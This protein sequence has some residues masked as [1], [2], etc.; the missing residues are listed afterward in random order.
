MNGL[1]VKL[2]VS[3]GAIEVRSGGSMRA[4]GT[5]SSTLMC[6]RFSDV[7]NGLGDV[8]RGV[9]A[10]LAQH[11]RRRRSQ[12]G[13]R[14][15]L[16][17]EQDGDRNRHDHGQSRRQAQTTVVEEVAEHPGMAVD[18]V[19]AARPCA[20]LRVSSFASAVA[21]NQSCTG[22]QPVR[23]G[24]WVTSAQSIALVSPSSCFR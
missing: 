14:A 20:L 3:T 9:T 2:S 24:F 22:C 12:I 7:F 21:A 4:C 6:G 23:S 8:V 18:R 15:E 16:E 13:E 1:S 19:P 17:I 10:Q 5:P 11:D